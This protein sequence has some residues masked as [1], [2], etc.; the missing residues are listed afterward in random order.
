MVKEEKWLTL[1]TDGLGCEAVLE[2]NYALMQVELGKARCH[3]LLD[4]GFPKDMA[5]AYLVKI[6]QENYSLPKR[7]ND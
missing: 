7:E 6:V 3:L 1:V 2:H 4:A 5:E